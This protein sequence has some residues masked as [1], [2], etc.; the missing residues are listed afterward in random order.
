MTFSKF[1]EFCKHLH[2]QCWIFF[3]FFIITE[4]LCTH[5]P[6]PTTTNLLCASINY[7]IILLVMGTIFMIELFCV[8]K[9]LKPYLYNFWQPYDIW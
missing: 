1:A 3:F 6:S 7:R 4:I 2:I 8:R 5:F 9:H